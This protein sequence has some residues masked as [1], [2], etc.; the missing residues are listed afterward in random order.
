MRRGNARRGV[1]DE[2]QVCGTMS[3]GRVDSGGKAGEGGWGVRGEK[4][5][6]EHSEWRVWGT[7]DEV[8]GAFSSGW[9][10]FACFTARAG[11]GQ[12]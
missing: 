8:N 3:D 11:G 2:N 7:M 10:D 9:K 6:G 1:I 4:G 5:G 12:K